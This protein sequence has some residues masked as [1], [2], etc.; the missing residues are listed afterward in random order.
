MHISRLATIVVHLSERE[1]Q[2]SFFR[3]GSGLETHAHML[4]NFVNGSYII[5]ILSIIWN[6]FYVTKDFINA[7]IWEEI[8]ANPLL[9]IKP[10]SL[11]KNKDSLARAIDRVGV[12]LRKCRFEATLFPNVL[13]IHDFFTYIKTAIK[14][15]LDRKTEKALENKKLECPLQF[16]LS[17]I[18]VSTFWPAFRTRDPSK[19]VNFRLF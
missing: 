7:T 8:K 6:R 12:L 11:G 4:Y 15:S 2:Q 3:E 19:Q 17:A 5:L 13:S 16:S 10:G 9:H 18:L 14:Y 1:V